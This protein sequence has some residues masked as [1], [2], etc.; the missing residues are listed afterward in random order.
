MV[1]TVRSY[2]NSYDY[3]LVIH[4]Q[5]SNKMNKI[6]GTVGG[7]LSLLSIFIVSMIPDQDGNWTLA[8][9]TVLIAIAV[10]MQIRRA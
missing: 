4:R 5:K 3:G 9:Y 1:N 8:A 10:F 6:Y 7:A 2:D